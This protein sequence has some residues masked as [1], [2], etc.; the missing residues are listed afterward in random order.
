MRFKLFEEYSKE[1][2]VTDNQYYTLVLDP[3]QLA[4]DVH[5]NKNPFENW[6]IKKIEAMFGDRW[7]LN[8][9]YDS[10]WL[11]LWKKDGFEK[12]TEP[13]FYICPLPDEYYRVVLYPKHNREM[14]ICDQLDGLKKLILD[15]EYLLVE[16]LDYNNSKLTE[17]EFF[18]EVGDAF[19]L[20]QRQDFSDAEVKKIQD[21][22]Y[23]I[24]PKWKVDRVRVQKYSKIPS[25][26]GI[27]LNC[28]WVKHERYY[29]RSMNEDS[30]IDIEVRKSEDSWYYVTV[31]EIVMGRKA[32]KEKQTY[33]KCDQLEGLLD[34][35]KNIVK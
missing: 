20:I 30:A 4:Q 27:M 31:T 9:A 17:D 11:R 14:Y 3:R 1:V 13:D 18:D 28:D 35:I 7:V 22:V 5:S 24:N 19:D 16:S 12:S 26:V 23:S 29:V 25:P 34:T 8:F 15:K 33:Y 32:T 10:T 2:H 6:E 21:F